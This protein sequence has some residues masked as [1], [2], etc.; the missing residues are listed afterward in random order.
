MPR[1]LIAQLDRKLFVANN[2]LLLVK[3]E[4]QEGDH[5]GGSVQVDPAVMQQ[6]GEMELQLEQTRTQ[7]QQA[8]VDGQQWREELEQER[9]GMRV[10]KRGAVQL[11]PRWRKNRAVEDAKQAQEMVE[12]MLKEKKDN[13]NGEAQEKLLEVVGQLQEQLQGQKNML[14]KY[15]PRL[16]KKEVKELSKELK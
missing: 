13:N 15:E 16:K 9:Q 2:E 4:V 14:M 11:R 10:G 12:E 5:V 6:V 1:L 8:L 3:K 7:L